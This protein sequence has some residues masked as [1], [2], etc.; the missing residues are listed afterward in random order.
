VSRACR[1]ARTLTA[2]LALSGTRADALRGRV[3]A[4]FER[5]ASMRL[6][7]VAPFGPPRF[8]LVARGG[9][10]TLLLPRDERVVHGAS[11]EDVLVRSPAWRWRP[12]I[13]TRAH[14]LRRA[15]SRRRA[16]AA[17]TPTGGRR[18]I[19]TATPCCI[20]RA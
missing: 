15:R 8:I 7:G 17:C 6:E 16:A 4:G 1:G 14:R 13:C 18:S 2:E 5:P 12:P 10:A 19:S 11:P 3:V 9:E 20:S